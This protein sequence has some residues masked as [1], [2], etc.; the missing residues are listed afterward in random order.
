MTHQCV[1]C[2]KLYPTAS[3]ELLSGCSCG[4]HFFFFVREEALPALQEETAD[5]TT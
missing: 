4:S 5:L 1:H 2:G 3:K